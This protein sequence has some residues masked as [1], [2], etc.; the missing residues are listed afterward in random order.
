MADPNEKIALVLSGG[1]A[2]GAYAAG[3]LHYLCT[4]VAPKLSRKRPFDILCGS[5]VGAIN[6]CFMAATCHNLE[7]QG[8]QIFE[9]W[10]NLD[11]SSVYRRDMKTLTRFMGKIAGKF[12]GNIFSRKTPEERRILKR[13]AL[14]KGLL[15]TSPFPVFLRESIP[16]RQIPINLQNGSLKA[17]SVTATNVNTGKMELFIHKHDS[18][19]YT[20][21]HP[22]HFVN[23]EFRHAMAS[24]AIPFLFPTVRVERNYYCDGGLR[25]NTPLSPAIQ[26]EADKVLVI[27]LH[28][29]GEK[30]EQNKNEPFI[31]NDLPPSMGDVAGQVL[32]S[33]FLDHLDYDL[34]QL[35]R[36]N[37]IIHWGKT[38]YG[39]DFVTK[40]NDH[41]RVGSEPDDIAARGLKELQ[42]GSVFP[43]VDIRNL[44]SA[45]VGDPDFLKRSLTSFEKMLL[46]LLE[47]DLDKSQDVLSFILFVPAY[48]RSMLALG[49]EDGKKKHD[50]FMNFF[51]S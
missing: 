48:L 44:F 6:T 5:S 31:E 9:L 8:K 29:V 34:E 1:G 50:Y 40:I 37:K 28:H 30:A 3:V 13:R 10:N 25:L 22:A 27:G 20:G 41:L 15:D 14:F 32:K 38:V 43:S 51:E 16:W 42:I 21:R 47:I 17:L 39:P 46:R 45:C 18:I 49:Y 36:I 11:Q 24:A 35:G 33:L 23:I 26:L 7:Y 4:K 12:V 19:R 2:R